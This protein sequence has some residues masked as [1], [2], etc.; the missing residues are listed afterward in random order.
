MDRFRRSVAIAWKAVRAACIVYSGWIAFLSFGF[1]RI[2]DRP[3]AY[4]IVTNDPDSDRKVKATVF[5]TDCGAMTATR[6]IVKF[7]N[8]LV[9]GRTFGDTV[10]VLTDV[11]CGD[12]HTRWDTDR[13]FAVTYPKA[14]GVEFA[15]AKMHGVT[16]RLN[17]E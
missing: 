5:T 6:T 9:D 15:V 14:A 7:S 4:S 12:I 1:Q 16:I 10:L 8:A 2:C 3:G 11:A 17:P 13:E